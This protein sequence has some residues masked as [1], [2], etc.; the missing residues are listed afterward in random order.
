MSNKR[1]EIEDLIFGVRAVI[2][3]IDARKEINKIMVQRGMDKALFKELKEALAN[4]KYTL[5]FVPAEKL[6]RLTQENHQGVIAFISPV[7][8]HELSDVLSDVF[9]RGDIPN[10]L[11]LDRIT[12]RKSTRLNSSHVRISYAVFC[13]KKKKKKY[14]THYIVI[15]VL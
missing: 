12:D 13:L 10:I 2:E 8:Y 3:A 5:Q 15:D 1:G 7:I 4:K 14:I 9:E 6:T 11:V